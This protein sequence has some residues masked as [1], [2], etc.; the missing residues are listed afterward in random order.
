MARS[1]KPV[2]WSLFAAG[3]TFAAFITP[4]MIVVTGLAVSLGLLP[5]ETLAYDRVLAVVQ[6]PIGKG[7]AFLT[8]FLP[9]WHAAHRLR[10][11]AHD[12]GIRA[13]TAVM[14]VCYSLAALATL[15]ALFALFR[16]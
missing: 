4:V 5:A 12:F 2:I 3:G 6:H 10:I 16:V 11:T 9:A 8:V 13:D 1:H 15:V 7:L 14:A